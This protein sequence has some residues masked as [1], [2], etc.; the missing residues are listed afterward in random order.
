MSNEK[1][2]PLANLFN[3]AQL[4]GLSGV[5]RKEKENNP[6]GIDFEALDSSSKKSRPKT[7]PKPKD[8]ILQ[9]DL[10][11]IDEEESSS[12][13]EEDE[14]PPSLEEAPKAEEP[15]VVKQEE[16][17]PE[18]DPEIAL[19]LA[20]AQQ[21]LMRAKIKRQREKEAKEEAEKAQQRAREREEQEKKSQVADRL[22]N[23]SAGHKKSA[24]DL[25]L[26][27]M[28]EPEKPEKPKKK[29]KSKPPT[30]SSAQPVQKANPKPKPKKR[31]EVVK[32]E[33]D[34]RPM[35]GNTL[36]LNITALIQNHLPSLAEFH[37]ASSMDTFNRPQ[38]KA[39]WMTKRTQFLQSGKLEYAVAALSVLDAL[40]T[41]SEGHLVAA[42]VETTASDY[43][44][45]VD[46]EQNRLV[47]AFANAGEYFG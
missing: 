9:E 26:E 8:D 46:R 16:Q 43:L 22:A 32:K 31:K 23:I 12:S 36:S 19:R 6:L 34:D 7:P 13:D 45:W 18:E 15:V 47:A 14:L 41:V 33:K 10:L 20:L 28:E 17:E 5:D 4:S 44:I 42:Y 21:A 27:A 1:F 2:D 40:E 38:L 37:V 29:A 35:M 3:M 24:M 25:F 39:M 30:K 11:E